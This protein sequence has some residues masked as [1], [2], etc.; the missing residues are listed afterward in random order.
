[1]ALAEGV[2][3][4]ARDG[5]ELCGLFFGR[6]VRLDALLN[7]LGRGDEEYVV[8]LGGGG[9]VVVEVVDYEAGAVGG[10]DDV[11]LGEEGDDGRGNRVVGG[12]GDEDVAVCVHEVDELVR[13]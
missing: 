8:L 10:E 4:A 12:K 2:S 13:R 3:D 7:G 6:E 11:E 1:M 5:D 9:G